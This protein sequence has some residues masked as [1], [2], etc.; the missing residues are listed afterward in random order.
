MAKRVALLIPV[1]NAS[2][3]IDAALSSLA[4]LIDDIDEIIIIDD[5]STD[6]TVNIV[7][8][9]LHLFDDKLVLLK[10]KESLGV[11]K[12]LNRG[13]LASSCEFILRFDGDDIIETNYLTKYLAIFENNSEVVA[14]G[15]N[16]KLIDKDDQV[17][18]S[19]NLSEGI[20]S[21][22][23]YSS[24]FIHPTVMFRRESAIQVGLYPD[25]IFGQDLFFFY[26]LSKKGL[27]YNLAVSAIRYRIHPYSSSRRS[28][29]LRL[30]FKLAF[31]F[32]R[33]NPKTLAISNKILSFFHN[34]KTE[35]SKYL[36]Y[37]LTVSVY[38]K[39][40]HPD[41]RTFNVVLKIRRVK[42]WR[43]LFLNK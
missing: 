38:R 18:T 36:D 9:H 7:F 43:L 33:L 8:S 29:F 11:A 23:G 28:V 42:F 12:A 24:P 10:N 27:L 5:G 34:A 30:L 32:Y 31:L 3:F 41:L 16:A 39:A 35:K 17:L 15:T 20:V 6:N 26:N 19:F 22:V 21:K 13:I 25:V 40:F 1:R 4:K 14:C 2:K 37:L